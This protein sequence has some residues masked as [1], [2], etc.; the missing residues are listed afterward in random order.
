MTS[1]QAREAAKASIQTEYNLAAPPRI[2]W[3][4]L[5]DSVLLAAWLM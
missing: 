2:V 1:N 5:T 4:A 3:R